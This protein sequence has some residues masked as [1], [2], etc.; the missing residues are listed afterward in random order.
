MGSD[1]PLPRAGPRHPRVNGQS[2]R[3]APGGDNGAA[4][5]LARERG[6]RSPHRPPPAAG[7]ACRGPREQPPL[8]PPNQHRPWAWTGGGEQAVPRPRAAGRS[9]VRPAA[10]GS[11]HPQTDPHRRGSSHRPQPGL[12]RGPG[13]AHLVL[14]WCSRGSPPGTERTHSRPAAGA[15]SAE[16]ASPRLASPQGRLG[17]RRKA[18]GPGPPRP[19]RRG[20]APRPTSRSP[21]VTLAPPLAKGSG[22]APS[23]PGHV[24]AGRPVTGSRSSRSPQPL[25]FRAASVCPCDAA[26][27][28]AAPKPLAKPQGTGGVGQRGETK[29]S[30]HPRRALG[31]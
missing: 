26:G 5:E 11:G 16:L 9:E 29:S 19:V 20:H 30:P 24:G 27:Q 13:S 2:A 10:R 31:G 1:G 22:P 12:S 23:P 3:S 21:G 4:G 25:I 18:A 14:G 17:K 6:A 28:P 8:A 15:G 7:S